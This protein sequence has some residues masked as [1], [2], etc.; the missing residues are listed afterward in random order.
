MEV[1]IGITLEYDSSR[2]CKIPKFRV[3]WDIYGGRDVGSRF[4]I[5]SKDLY[6]GEILYED[7]LTLWRKLEWN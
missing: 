7:L 6:H 5:P 3:D 1:E 2:L 4:E